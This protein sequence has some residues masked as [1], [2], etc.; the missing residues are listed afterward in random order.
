MGMSWSIRCIHEIQQ[1]VRYGAIYI[2]TLFIEI[3]HTGPIRAF[4]Y[5]GVRMFI[6]DDIDEN[7]QHIELCVG[8]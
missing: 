2:H 6:I 8:S 7:I 1:I 3:N 5:I 4:N